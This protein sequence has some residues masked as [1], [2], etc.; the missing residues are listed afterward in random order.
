MVRSSYT[1]SWAGPV[2]TACC[3]IHSQSPLHLFSC[4]CT[5]CVF[6]FTHFLL[7]YVMTGKIPDGIGALV[8]RASLDWTLYLQNNYLSGTYNINFMFETINLLCVLSSVQFDLP[9]KKTKLRA[10]IKL[11]NTPAHPPRPLFFSAVTKKE[12]SPII[13]RT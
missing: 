11:R 7:L 5:F 10:S 9:F 8:A 3:C 12:V 13:F 4:L 1:G 2:G 6:L